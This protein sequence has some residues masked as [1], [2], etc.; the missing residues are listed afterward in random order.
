MWGPP[1]GMMYPRFPPGGPPPP[2][3]TQHSGPPLR[4]LVSDGQPPPSI[5]PPQPTQ[6]QLSEEHTPSPQDMI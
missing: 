5:G 1:P 3:M 4:S 2:H 6:R